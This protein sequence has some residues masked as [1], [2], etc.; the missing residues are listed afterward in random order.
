MGQEEEEKGHA[1][2]VC[3]Q[4]LLENMR[5]LAGVSNVS[6]ELR[7]VLRQPPVVTVNAMFQRHCI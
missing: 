6:E 3:L 2:D 5:R 1:F 4:A 7:D